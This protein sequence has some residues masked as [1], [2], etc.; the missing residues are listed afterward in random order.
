MNI[1]PKLVDP[2]FKKMLHISLKQC[3]SMKNKY[4]NTIFNISMF[5]LLVL[6]IGF[7]LFIKY[8]GK[9][10]PKQKEEKKQKD[11]AFIFTK[12]KQLEMIKKKQNNELIT[13][14]PMMDHP[15]NG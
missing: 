7:I 5:A 8:K 13:N 1:T 11:K 14:L 12:L 15:F 4:I 3:N 9:L 6:L 2:Y 10:T